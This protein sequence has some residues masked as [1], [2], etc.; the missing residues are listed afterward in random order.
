MVYRPAD[1]TAFGGTVVVEWLNAARAARRRWTAPSGSR[2][3]G[4]SG[5]APTATP[6]SSR[7]RA[8]RT[9]RG[10]CGRRGRGSRTA[11]GSGYLPA[12]G[13]A[14]ERAV[15]AGFLL[16]AD[17]DEIVAVAAAS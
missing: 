17:L 16:A 6:R 3:R 10:C 13:A 4:A 2:G 11:S 8:R 7:C 9:W 1:P 5:S 15:A 12:F 14:A